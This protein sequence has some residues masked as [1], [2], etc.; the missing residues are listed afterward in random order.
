MGEVKNIIFDFDGTLADTSELIV[1]TMQKSIQD[2]RLPFK[3]SQEIKATIGIRLEEIPSILWP[4]INDI[5]K[6]FAELYRK[7]FE[8]IKKIVPVKLFPEIKETLD[9]LSINNYKMAIATSRSLK[10]VEELA[11]SLGIKEKFSYI[12]G[13]DSVANGK[14]DPESLYLIMDA[15]NWNKEQTMM[16]GDMDVDIKMGKR[17]GIQTCGVTYGNG[18]VSDLI[19]TG[20]DN[21][22]DSIGQIRKILN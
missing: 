11:E 2:A 22:I 19:E 1:T 7:N 8:E 14:P 20:A 18:K 12:L 21:L 9:F 10:S 6:K 4:Q 3:S 15:M 5:D 17:A 16:V 13:G